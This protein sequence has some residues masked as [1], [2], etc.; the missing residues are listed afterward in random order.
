MYLVVIVNCACGVVVVV[1]GHLLIVGLLAIMHAIAVR[2][3]GA[4][5]L[6]I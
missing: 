3:L 4:H 6:S 5:H 1:L 2:C